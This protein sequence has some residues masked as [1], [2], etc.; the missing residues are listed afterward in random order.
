ML[1][2]F[3]FRR[4]SVMQC[5]SL[6]TSDA[7]LLAPAGR[8]KMPTT[9]ND[10]LPQASLQTW[11]VNGCTCVRPV[12][13]EQNAAP[14]ANLVVTYGSIAWAVSRAF[15]GCK[16]LCQCCPL[17]P[18]PRWCCC[19]C[20]PRLQM[21]LRLLARRRRKPHRPHRPQLFVS[22]LAE[23]GHVDVVK[24]LLESNA[25]VTKAKTKT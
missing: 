22:R 6:Q 10:N 4:V 8:Q 19:L 15:S 9:A 18:D 23:R 12:A 16:H 14:N 20:W 3:F 21:A 7:D 13:N 5:S 17:H 24:V 11:D 2:I 1:K 25:D